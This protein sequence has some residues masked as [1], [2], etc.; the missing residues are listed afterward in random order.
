MNDITLVCENCKRS[1]DYARSIDP[2]IPAEVVKITQ[3][4]CDVCWNG[5]FEDETWWD[6]KGKEVP[7]A[8]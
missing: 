7:Q 8:A 4:H 6:A 3:P 2:T 5:D 1:M